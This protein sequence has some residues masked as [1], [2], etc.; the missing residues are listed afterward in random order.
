MMDIDDG[1]ILWTGIWKGAR[2]ESGAARSSLL[3]LF[4][5]ML[6]LPLDPFLALGNAKGISCK[7]LG[8]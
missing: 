4:H 2:A 1:Y 6:L 8:E 5:A 7:K 3:I